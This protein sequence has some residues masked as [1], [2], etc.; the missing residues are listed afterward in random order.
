D[1][2]EEEEDEE[3]SDNEEENVDEENEEESDD[4]DKSINITNTDDERTESDFDNHGMSKEGEIVAETEEKETANSE[5]KED[6]TKVDSFLYKFHALEKDVQELKQVDHSA[7]ILE[8]IRSQAVSDF[9]TP[10]VQSTIKETLKKTPVVSDQSSSQPNPLIL[11][12]S[13][14]LDKDLFESYGQTV[15]LKRNR[16]DDQDEDPS[17]GTNQGKEKKKR[18]TR[19]EAESS[20]KSFTPKEST[21]GDKAE[22]IYS[23][24]ITKT[25][26]SRAMINKK[27]SHV[28]F[29]KIRI[30][31]VVN[32]EVEKKCDYGYLKEIVVRRADQQLYKFKEGLAM[33][34]L[35][36]GIVLQSRV[37]DVQLCVESY[38]RKLNL[39]IPQRSCPGMSA[40]E[41]YT[42]N[43]DPQGVIYKDKKKKKRLMRVDEL[44]K[45]SDGTLQY[46]HKT[47]L[48]RLKNFRLEYN[49]NSDMTR[50]E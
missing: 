47:L 30:L 36:R 24:S 8:S 32:V 23:S 33:R 7:T 15:S 10:V 34:M 49:P 31:S 39:I 2:N 19:K 14:P 26:A 13:Y 1:V 40:K 4:N 12:N 35:T 43:Y 16:E 9:A 27:S 11:V 38:Q 17:A 18:R 48:H 6:D 50:K 41:I 21:K 3:Q 29:S 42:L 37:E 28:V 25:R 46:V 20:K 22:R 44:H 45:F 5:H